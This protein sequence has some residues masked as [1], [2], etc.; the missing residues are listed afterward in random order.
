LKDIAIKHKTY[1]HVISANKAK[2]CEF[3]SFILH[4]VASCYDGEVKVWPEYKLSGSH[5]KEGYQD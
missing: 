2:K 1:I 3:I 5:S 4:G